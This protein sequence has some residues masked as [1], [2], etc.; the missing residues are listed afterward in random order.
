M[1]LSSGSNEHTQTSSIESFDLLQVHS[2]QNLL[3]S[4]NN[5]V[6]IH[7]AQAT[8]NILPGNYGL[9]CA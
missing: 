5:K 3:Q 7:N 1:I 9:I 2:L 8:Q 6:S 4:K